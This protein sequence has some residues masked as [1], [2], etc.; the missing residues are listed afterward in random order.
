MYFPPF[1]P[2]S[3]LVL[4]LVLFLFLYVGFVFETYDIKHECTKEVD[5]LWRVCL[6]GEGKTMR[7]QDLRAM[8]MLT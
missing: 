6:R 1:L 4:L 7:I 2:R 3:F 8:N 5:K